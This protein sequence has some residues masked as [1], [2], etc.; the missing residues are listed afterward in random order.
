MIATT[1]AGVPALALVVQKLPDFPVS[2]WLLIALA[3]VVGV[4]AA[5]FIVKKII[6]WA[7][8]LAVTAISLGLVSVPDINPFN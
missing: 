7:I 5:V 1:T 4:C 3:V 6:G 8:G 2:S